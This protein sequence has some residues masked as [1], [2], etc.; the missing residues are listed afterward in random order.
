[1]MRW[2]SPRH[3]DLQI[4]HRCNLRCT[5]CYAGS[6]EVADTNLGVIRG[7]VDLLLAGGRSRVRVDLW[8]GEPLTRPD[9]VLAAAGLARER[10]EALGV[11]VMV[12]MATN[13]TLLTPRLVRD[14]QDA[15]VW[16]SLSFEPMGLAPVERV[17]PGGRSAWPLVERGLDA[18]LQ[19]W[20]G[21]LPGVRLTV[22]PRRVRHLVSEVRWLVEHGFR[23]FSALPA[24]GAPWGGEST[25][26][27]DAALAE[28]AQEL[29]RLIQADPSG[30][31]VFPGLARRAVWQRFDAAHGTGRVGSCGAGATMFAVDTD[32]TLYPCHRLVG[33]GPALG[34][35]EHGVTEPDLVR[36]L[37]EVTLE[38]LALPDGWPAGACRP[39][40]VAEHW[41]AHR[42]LFV[43]P[44]WV[45]W[46][47][48]RLARAA[49][50]MV[51]LVRDEAALDLYLR[52]F[53]EGQQD[54]RV[55]PWLGAL[56][57][58]EASILD[59]AMELLGGGG[60]HG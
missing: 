40:C 25:N 43:V 32:G 2:F 15:G 49:A 31:P 4:T 56:Q 12:S 44:P 14:L 13:V 33:H 34:S 23:W 52:R 47:N 16:P 27:L 59:R 22:T 26:D 10:G 1:M 38:G 55:L 3:L 53:S 8:G 30:A 35:L 60:G 24:S 54:E 36:R 48:Q 50:L 42:D 9:L 21:P 46:L 57:D 5:Y 11:E 18:L 19:A 29:A 6:P 37:A 39:W 58:H 51:S 41:R 17:L 28:V 7:A 20:R 45:C